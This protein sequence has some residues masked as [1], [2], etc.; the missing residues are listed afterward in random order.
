MRKLKVRVW[1]PIFIALTGITITALMLA[2]EDDGEIPVIPLRPLS[3]ETVSAK[4]RD[5]RIQISAWGFVEP[6]DSVDIRSEISG[7]IDHIPE[8]IYTGAKIKKNDL[9]FELDDRYYRNALKEAKASRN[10]VLQSLE[11]E[12]GKQ[13]VARKEWNLLRKSKWSGN[14]NESLALRKPQLKEREAAVQIANAKMSQAALDVER[15]RINSPCN[16]VIISENIGKG[17]VIASE[18]VVMKIGCTDYFYITAL[19]SPEF[20]IDTKIKKVSVKIGNRFFNGT[21]KAVSPGINAET[22]HKEVLVAL[23][24][25]SFTIGAY[26]KLMLPG[27]NFRGVTVLPKEALRQGSTVWVLND[28]DTLEIREVIVKGKDIDN[29]VIERGLSESD[30]VIL[31]HIASPLSGMSLSEADSVKGKSDKFVTKKDMEQIND[32][33]F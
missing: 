21:I 24:E 20:S 8:N 27:K 1:L 33:L 18:D 28:D 2:F 19:F 32:E 7:K 16:G 22:R 30:R 12:K 11:I 9:L 23:K 10:L 31:T 5:Y 26:A 15:T 3:V 6:C 14:S 25:N 4:K 29:I 17:K 13:I